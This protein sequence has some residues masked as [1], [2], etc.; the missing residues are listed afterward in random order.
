MCSRIALSFQ[1]IEDKY[2][3]LLV[4]EKAVELKREIEAA[5]VKSRPDWVQKGKVGENVESESEFLEY[6]FDSE[7]YLS[8]CAVVFFQDTF[9]SPLVDSLVF[10]SL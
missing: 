1:N 3:Q 10:I 4:E 6:I 2:K 8:N 9:T 7:T 5:V